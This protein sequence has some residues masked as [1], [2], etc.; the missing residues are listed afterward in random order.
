MITPM[1]SKTIENLPTSRDY[2]YEI[3][4]D[5]QRTIAE[6][7]NKKLL[8]YTR[9]FQNVTEKYPE[10]Q[11]LTKCITRK[12]VI[13]D[14]EIIALQH[15]IPSFELLQQRM[16]L[17]DARAVRR[18][19]EDV[20]VIYY[21]FD[22]LDLNGKTLLKTAL[23]ERKKLLKASV[24]PCETV[25]ILPFFDSSDFV[26]E[27]AQKM[28]YEGVV[29]KK[30]NSAYYPGQ[31]TDLWL[32]FKFQKTDSF[33]IGGWVEGGRS[34]G[35]GSILIGKYDGKSLVHCGRAGTGFDEAK[36]KWLMTKFQKLASAQNPF[37]HVPHTAERMHWLKPKLVAEVKFK[38]WTR[39]HIVRAPVFVGLRD[40]L[41]PSQCRM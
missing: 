22:I 23:L 24:K 19:V 35:F 31:R 8:L 37:L 1:L 20:P 14:G 38:E 12:S 7:S 3:K 11:I 36:I 40:D 18:A 6:V 29:A 2:I 28:G 41:N 21:V 5:G 32:K 17:R 27:A 30:K 9:N 10:L 16:S 25:K 33:V 39:A 26:L 13:L 34:Y 15:G 4:L